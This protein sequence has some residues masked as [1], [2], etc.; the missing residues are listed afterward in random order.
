MKKLIKEMVLAFWVDLR[1]RLRS[2]KTV[3]LQGSGGWLTSRIV[4]IV[5]VIDYLAIGPG[6]ASGDWIVV[7]GMHGTHLKRKLPSPIISFK[8]HN[9]K[10]RHTPTF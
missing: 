6:S 5:I 7:P 3:P 4:H 8:Q 1:Y 10:N 2:R 9:I